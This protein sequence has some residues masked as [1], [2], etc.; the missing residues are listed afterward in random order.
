MHL[1]ALRPTA[2][3]GTASTVA[4]T[5]AHCSG[6][7]AAPCNMARQALS[8]LEDPS[9][10]LAQFHRLRGSAARPRLL[11]LPQDFLSQTRRHFP[12]DIILHEAA[13]TDGLLSYIA[14]A[15]GPDFGCAGLPRRQLAVAHAAPVMCE[16]NLCLRLIDAGCELIHWAHASQP[17]AVPCEGL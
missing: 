11:P 10:Y 7:R 5:I 6:C 15:L 14:P 3:H 2:R 12:T 13:D 8:H 16:I 17:L 4:G 1:C 9:A